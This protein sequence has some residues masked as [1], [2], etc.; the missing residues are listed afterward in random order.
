MKIKYIALI[1]S[2]LILLF[3]TSCTG[4]E[5]DPM[6]QADKD[7]QEFC[8]G[9]HG[10]NRLGGVG[11]NLLPERLFSTLTEEEI[12]DVIKN[13]REGTPM[14][15]FSVLGDEKIN[16]LIEYLKTPV[17]EE[18][19]TFTLEDA[20]AS[21]TVINPE[22]TLP[23]H[24]TAWD[25]S[26]LDIED[27]M[28]A[29]ER[30]TR[31][32]AVMDG[33]NHELLGHID[34]S[35]RTHTIQWG[36]AGTS[37][38]RYM[39]GVGRDGW[40]FKVDMYSFKT[41]RKV[42]VGLDSRGIAVSNDGE[43]I[44]VG[45][46]LPG[47]YAIV[48]KNL[49][50]LTIVDTVNTDP[51]GQEVHS[52]VGALL[53]TDIEHPEAEQMFLVVLKDGGRVL[54]IDASKEGAEKGFPVIMDIP[55]VGRNLHD[56]F[57]DEEGRYLM[58]ASR[59]DANKPSMLDPSKPDQGHMAII[60]VKEGKL[61]SQ[62]EA[63]NVPHTG[64][65]AVIETETYGTIY[66]TPASVDNLVTFWKQTDD[67]FEVIK[68]VSLGKPGENGGSLFIRSYNGI[69]GVGKASDYVWV[70]IA[71]EPNWQK[72]F[73]IHKETLEVVKE[74]DTAKLAGTDPQITR[75]VH[76]E[77]TYDGKYVY[78]ALWDADA[79]LVFTPDG[80]F[81]KKIEGT[82]SPTGIFNYGV[83]AVEPGV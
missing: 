41:V 82:T 51:D 45:N 7:Y 75:S 21:L 23:D 64:P 46:Y 27:L 81:V 53:Q 26:K 4:G 8:A 35:Y 1:F 43:Y 77:F 3:A 54:G 18:Q 36:P 10:E 74:I 25:D 73:V 34:G 52:K 33:K 47:G 71:F 13:G 60:D 72:V 49:N 63:G 37:E 2:I 69:E 20:R 44:I 66:A 9:C 17:S 65:G 58:V 70:D 30:E 78:V 11:P 76:P 29:M 12:Y 55:N 15:A 14:P 24:P 22:E 56:A 67:D 80:E 5:S 39:Y 6:T 19:Q 38:G 28:V 16:Q 57:F 68:Q 83:R 32:Y 59:G 61:V 50:P 62:L 79:V 48:D 31:Q 40:L 42:R